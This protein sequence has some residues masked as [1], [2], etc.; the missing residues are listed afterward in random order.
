MKFRKRTISS[1]KYFWETNW[2]LRSI[3]I[4][5][6]V[7]LLNSLTREII[8]ATPEKSH[9][10][11][12]NVYD[13]SPHKICSYFK[14]CLILTLCIN[15]LNSNFSINV[16]HSTIKLFLFEIFFNEQYFPKYEC[17]GLRALEK[18]MFCIFS[19]NY[20]FSLQN[21]NILNLHLDL[22]IF[23]IGNMQLG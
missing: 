15:E 20:I 10:K 13:H 4:N 22:T 23:A 8:S 2:R 14:M 9:E 3:N 5:I 12:G 7:W 21:F 6:K 16:K 11:F 18:L 17:R 1:V 19:L